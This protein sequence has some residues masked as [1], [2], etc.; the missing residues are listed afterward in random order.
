MLASLKFPP[1]RRAK[2]TPKTLLPETHQEKGT[3]DLTRSGNS[4]ALEHG[5]I[6]RALMVTE[7][8]PVLLFAS[9]NAIYS[10]GWTLNRNL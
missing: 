7:W 3:L 8:L 9:K 4:N 1:P 2:D 5:P 6:I 10:V